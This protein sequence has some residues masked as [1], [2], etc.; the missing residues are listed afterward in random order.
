LSFAQQWLWFLDQVDPENPYYNTPIAVRLAGQLNVA[1]LEQSLR[2]L[3]RRH[4]ALRTTFA[5]VE[6]QPFQVIDLAPSLDWT[7]PVVD[8]RELP[9]SERQAEARRLTEAE[10]RRPFD[11]E[12]GPIWRARL[13]RLDPAEHVL[14]LT[15]HHVAFD[16]WSMGVLFRELAALYE[17]FSEGKPSPLAELPIQYADFAVWQRQW[18][19]G[20]AL[21]G[22]LSYWKRQLDDL[23]AL[24]L[25]TDRPRPPVQTHR[26]A[27]QSIALPESLTEDLK[28]LSRREGATLFMTLLA[29]FQTLMH[30]YTGQDDVVVGS[31]VAN[32]NRAEIEGLIGFF[33]NMLALR[34]D[35]SGNPTFQELLGRVREVAL[36][37]YAHQDV[38][39]EKLVEELKPERYTSGTPLFQVM[40]ALHNAPA[41]DLELAGLM[42]DRLEVDKGTAKVD[43]VLNTVEGP[44]GLRARL[45]YNA[46]LFDAATIERMLGH[47]RTLLKDIVAGPEKRLSELAPLVEA[48]RRPVSSRRQA[49]LQERG[50]DLEVVEAALLEEDTVV[51]CA[52][53]ARETE[54]GDMTLVAYVV[55][56]G[57]FSPE[58]LREPL[59]TRLP[60]A[61]VPSAYVSVS[62]LPL[63]RTGQI[64]ERA[65]CRLPVIDDLLM[66]RWEQHLESLPEVDQVALIAEEKVRRLPSL[67]LDDLL[68][69]RMPAA[70]AAG[71]VASLNDSTTAK[72][73]E[74]LMALADG[75]RLTIPDDAPETLTEALLRNATEH[76]DKGITYVRSDGSE[77]FESYAALLERARRILAG[78]Q[79][80]GLKAGD[81]LILQVD[82]LEDHYPAFWAC[83]LGGIA[84]ATVAVA[85]S[86][87]ERNG[88]V[89]KLFSAWELLGHP[90]ILTSRHLVEPLA[91]LARLL[92]M[93]DLTILPVDELKDSLPTGRI[94]HSRPDDLAFLQLTS[95]STGVPKCI[96][97]VHRSIVAH[98]HA[99]RQ[100]DGYAPD[101][102]TLNWMPVDHVGAMIMWHLRD[103][104]LGCQQV[105]VK[106]ELILADPLKW[107]DL[108]EAHR[109]NYT[110][111]PNFGYKLVADQLAK[112]TDRRWDLSRM[113]FFLNGGEQVTLPVARDFLTRVAPFG[114]SERAMQ[115]AYGGAETCTRITANNH[116]DVRT[117][118]RRFL[119][120]SLEGRLQ[121]SEADGSTTTTFIDVGSPLPG[122]QLRIVDSN[123]ELL[124]EGAI[125]R[126][127]IKGP[128][129]TPGYLD[130]DAANKEAFVGDGWLSLGDLGFILDGHLS[131]TGREKETIRVRGATFYSHEIED[132]VNAV[133]GVEPTFV[134]TCAI[135]DPATGTE[136]FAVFFVPK[137]EA[138]EDAVEL[139]R[140]IRARV[141]ASLGVSPTY[142]VPLATEDFPKTTSGKI[143]RGQLKEAFEAGRF[144]DALKALDVALENANTL[145]DWFYRRTWRR[146]EA[147]S[148]ANPQRSFGQTL[149]LLDRSG[150]GA[151][152][153]ERARRDG[154]PWVEVEVGP[155]FEKL[156]RNRYR[157]DPGS[158]ADHQRLLATLAQDGISVEEVVHLWSYGANAGEITDLHTLEAAQERG[159]CSL[160]FLLQALAQHGLSSDQQVR[161][162]VVSSHAQPVLPSDGVACE[163]GPLLGL[164]RTAPQEWPWLECHHVD[165]QADDPEADADAVLHELRAVTADQE[166]AYRDGRRWVARLEH[167]DLRR[168]QARPLPFERGGLYLVTGGLGGVASEV[169]EYL[170]KEHEARLL[171]V[172]RTPLP[173]PEVW[174]TETRSDTVAGRIAAYRALEQLGGE[175][176]YRSADVADPTRLR[177]VVAE[178]ETRWGRPLDGIIHLAGVFEER[179]L[180]E[181]T[182]E[183]FM[184]SLRP[185][186]QG[187]WALHELAKDRPDCAF[188]T[189]SSAHGLLGAFGAGAYAAANAFLD[190]FAHYRRHT[191]LPSACF[192][193]GL[194]HEVGM[195]RGYPLKELLISR[196]FPPISPEQGLNSFLAGLHRDQ[197]HL[198]VG[199]DATRPHIGRHVEQPAE[200]THTLRAYFT[201]RNGRVPTARSDGQ[202][203]VRDR[204]GTP[205]ACELVR[206]PELPL[207]EAG[208]I[209]RTRLVDLGGS[210]VTDKA[211]PKPE[212]SFVD[213][214][215][216]TEVELAGIWADVL[217]L[218][219]VGVDDVFFEL[220][221]HSLLA[222]QVVTRL[223]RHFGVELP[224]RALFDTPT[225]AGLA[226]AVTQARAEAETDID[227]MLAQLEQAQGE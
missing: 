112:A 50:I 16:G 27:R 18:L 80:W 38:S 76:A 53:V 163:Q 29:A 109:V 11:L 154:R 143:Q 56:S 138:A 211:R 88:V 8:L 160:L 99:V 4:E 122:V 162:L 197:A 95:G 172:G 217:H 96:Q 39:F 174:D 45:D 69:E 165:L 148:P 72:G 127:Q 101:D 215:T 54:S 79:E 218:Q 104:Y 120:S 110:W 156:D 24:Q 131:L 145:P 169:A 73:E 199:L 126:L 149:V 121:E 92:P 184:A 31:P 205:S 61:L 103:T 161:V 90:P 124:P 17:A 89:D 84:P 40:F 186:L 196:G 151:S 7:L 33:A 91:G 181:E 219:R 200:S 147:S 111:S 37:A 140:T 152:L 198:L 125:G 204:F 133:E 221:G 164:V 100:S 71:S 36:G 64:D 171:L 21:E 15:I 187:T 206:V 6:G 83:I 167:A 203:E 81:R 51:D 60:E 188:I 106:T 107:L 28:E 141:A 223:N 87:A 192:A 210:A 41:L 108:L 10:A 77:T 63:T 66:Q 2:E 176:L 166:V 220:G 146:R 201:T 194:W 42:A 195:A 113:R 222:V 183:T 114:V 153:A 224:L 23:P 179:L 57:P 75:G 178:A 70:S 3:A 13:L 216:P 177:A 191:G 209:D 74:Q 132:V 226:L 44:E 128:V 212:A 117:G 135:A 25:P 5:S 207:T 46:D 175:V 157:I 19:Q 52:V 86:Y 173:E 134:G 118:A 202:E 208:A 150:L 142:V 189:F 20:E 43:L 62:A 34:T 158:P 130:N 14:L 85:P 227:Q 225:V 213:A 144:R 193:W 159:A 55:L 180:F 105:H 185:K 182:R 12:H 49:W 137:A 58:W 102:V 78:L 119:K 170:L 35:L 22:Q 68:P 94:H 214:R 26:G 67:H 98:A 82:A 155:A 136:G 116:F 93:D 30:R 48:Q 65:L 1:A 97:E 190:G 32:R 59:R 168:E 123:N 139:V 115:P 129:V 47:F 9:E